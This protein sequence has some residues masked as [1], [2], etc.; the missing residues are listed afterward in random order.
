MKNLKI[1]DVRALPGDSA[2]LLDD[3]KTSILYDTGYAFTGYKIAENIKKEL[4][5]RPLDYIFLTHSHYDHAL[6]SVYISKYYPYAKV[7]AGE[8]AAKI[9]NKESARAVMRDLD[10]KAAAGNGVYEYEDLIDD[11][12]VDIPVN[13]GDVIAAGDMDFEVISLP[14]HTRCSIGF[15]LRENKLLLSS[16]TLGVYYTDKTVMPS[17]LIGYDTTLE[18]IKKAKELEIESI[19]LPHFG[20]VN[21]NDTAHFLKKSEEVAIEV[22]ENMKSIFLSGGDTEDCINYLKDSFYTECVK[23]TYP[24]DAFRLNSG[25]MAELI[26]KELAFLKKE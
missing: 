7:A 1:I 15:Y 14:G 3:G 21:K 2:F 11:L 25:I 22:Y 8:Y 16:E 10:K 18:S 19:L 23:E 12:K 9:F 13:D 6:G 17:Y 4:G 20:I 24:I 5:S 26:K